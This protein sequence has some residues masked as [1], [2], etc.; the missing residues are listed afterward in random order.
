[1]QQVRVTSWQPFPFHPRHPLLGASRT[2]RISRE[3]LTAL[4]ESRPALYDASGRSMDVVAADRT[5]SEHVRDAR[6]SA[7][8][9]DTAAFGP[10]P[11]IIRTNTHLLRE[12]CQRCHKNI[13]S[14]RVHD[15]RALTASAS[16]TSIYP[17]IT[18]LRERAA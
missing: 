15:C 17:P 2:H 6:S 16:A 11:K 18:V 4:R 10:A 12:P 13:D 9:R 8:E 1:M 3:Q 14:A 7:R 5:E